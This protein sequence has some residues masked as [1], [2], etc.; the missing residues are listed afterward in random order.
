MLQKTKQESIIYQN[1]IFKKY[2]CITKVK[3]HSFK[4]DT[5]FFFVLHSL[6]GE[7][8]SVQILENCWKD[9][10]IFH[11]QKLPFIISSSFIWK[12]AIQRYKFNVFSIKLPYS[13]SLGLDHF[14]YPLHPC[15]PLISPIPEHFPTTN[16]SHLEAQNF[17]N[18]KW[19]G[20]Q[21]E[22]N[23]SFDIFVAFIV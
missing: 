16:I 6:S 14:P 22:K 7:L 19:R 17:D 21:E 11:F 8:T 13:F 3:V 23:A 4:S 10:L 20:G 5:F 1:N 12:R 2:Y 18:S 9:S 15:L